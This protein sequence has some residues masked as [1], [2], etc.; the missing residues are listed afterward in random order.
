MEMETVERLVRRHLATIG[1][2]KAYP[3][4]GK[5]LPFQSPPTPRYI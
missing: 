1:P 2:G 3:I 5:A 4:E